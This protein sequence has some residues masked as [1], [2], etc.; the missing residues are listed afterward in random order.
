MSAADRH[1]V[2][3]QDWPHTRRFLVNKLGQFAASFAG[4]ALAVWWLS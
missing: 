1:P 4:A 2:L 3:W